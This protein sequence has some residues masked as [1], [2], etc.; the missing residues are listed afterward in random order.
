MF[1]FAADADVYPRVSAGTNTL[2]LGGRET[3]GERERGGM[4]AA[5]ERRRSSHVQ[6]AVRRDGRRHACL[7]QDLPAL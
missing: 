7:D 4:R 5:K 3:G 1:N 2:G 6:L